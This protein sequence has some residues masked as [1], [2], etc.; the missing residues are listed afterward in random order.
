MKETVGEIEPHPIYHIAIDCEQ[1]FALHLEALETSVQENGAIVLSELN[2][3]FEAWAAF[4]GVFAERK[5][6][7]DRRLRAHPDLKDQVLRLVDILKRNLTY[8]LEPDDEAMHDGENEPSEISTLNSIPATRRL[9]IP[10]LE[11]ITSAIERLNHLGTAIRRSPMTNQ[12]IKAKRLASLNQFSSF[13]QLAY[14][15][16]KI[17]YPDASEDLLQHVTQSM[18]ETYASFRH[19][20]TR[21]QALQGRRASLARPMLSTISEG[22]SE[23]IP[24]EININSGTPISQAPPDGI[25]TPFDT[26]TLAPK[27]P[28]PPTV[29]GSDPTSVDS[30]EAQS[31]FRKL[32]NPSAKSKTKSI[33]MKQAEYPPPIKGGVTCD[34]CF[35]PL[36]ANSF[37]DS[38]V[39]QQH[40]NEDH[41]P[42][43]CLS[44]KCSDALFRSATSSKWFEHMLTHGQN[45]HRE[46]YAPWVWDCPLCHHSD[47]VDASFSKPSDFTDHLNKLH[48]DTFTKPQVQ[49][50]LRQS[51]CRSPRPRDI[52]LFCGFSMDPRSLEPHAVRRRGG[53]LN[54]KNLYESGSQDLIQKRLKTDDGLAQV[55]R[56]YGENLTATPNEKESNTQSKSSATEPLSV[57]I[58]ASHIASHLQGVLHLTLRLILI[59]GKRNEDPSSGEQGSSNDPRTSRA[60]S[61]PMDLDQELNSDEATLHG[62]ENSDMGDGPPLGDGI[63]VPNSDFNWQGISTGE[64]VSIEEDKFLQQ[65][66]KSGAY[67]GHLSSDMK[68]YMASMSE[69]IELEEFQTAIS[70]L[71]ARDIQTLLNWA[72][73]RRKI[74]RLVL[75][76]RI[77][78]L[79]DQGAPIRNFVGNSLPTGN[80][81]GPPWSCDPWQ[82]WRSRIFPLGDAIFREIAF[83]VARE[84]REDKFMRILDEAARQKWLPVRLGTPQGYLDSPDSRIPSY[85]TLSRAQSDSFDAYLNPVPGLDNIASASVSSDNMPD[86]PVWDPL[87]FTSIERS[88]Q[89]LD[90]NR[91]LEAQMFVNNGDHL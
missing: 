37:S 81:A 50:I 69:S 3:R 6:C 54:L 19:R 2:Q 43:I 46:V 55:E 11:A 70:D 12:S 16:L 18:A 76:I 89:Q 60:G 71:S 63:P 44:E 27:P 67:Q 9:S 4:L 73:L 13:S 35:G 10:S 66:I 21:Q 1:L 49:A 91:E 22:P 64:V 14:L 51:R 80:P 28:P 40:V 33:L 65:V 36:P 62:S 32:L 79:K 87:G 29:S 7:L 53:Q 34:W 31:K 74:Y 26:F 38:K 39:W 58:I 56:P 78:D 24:F 90:D 88:L 15:S 86:R 17:L 68:K 47:S 42:Y 72:L 61:S 52:C 41:Q 23:T 20:K 85:H 30:K 83:C 25:S 82:Y 59:D 57:E 45:W 48:P 84:H 75:A 8:L 77:E 5:R